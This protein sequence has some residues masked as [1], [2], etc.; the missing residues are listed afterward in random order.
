[1]SFLNLLVLSRD[2]AIVDE[3]IGREMPANLPNTFN[4]IFHHKK[5]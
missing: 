5:Y 2:N 3:M 4:V 1:M